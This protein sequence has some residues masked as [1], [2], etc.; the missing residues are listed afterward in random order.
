VSSFIRD[1]FFLA[2]LTADPYGVLEEGEIHFRSSEL[3]TDPESGTQMD[4]VT[5]SVLVSTL[6]HCNELS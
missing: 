5:G 2:H 3:I 1:R 4:T 6:V